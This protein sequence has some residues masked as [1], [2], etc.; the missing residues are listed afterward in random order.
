MTIN[1]TIVSSALRCRQRDNTTSARQHHAR[2]EPLPRIR[3]S[4]V[5]QMLCRKQRPLPLVASA[6]QCIEATNAARSAGGRLE[7]RDL[8]RVLHKA[9]DELA[10]PCRT[11]KPNVSVSSLMHAYSK[12]ALPVCITIEMGMTQAT[13]VAAWKVATAT[14]CG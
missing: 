5:R 1:K 13:N 7:R 9:G 11:A 6:D 2:C 4:F 8:L 12:G 3:T 14:W 10:V